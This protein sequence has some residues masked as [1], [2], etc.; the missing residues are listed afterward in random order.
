MR[1]VGWVRDTILSKGRTKIAAFVVKEG[2]WLRDTKILKFNDM[3]AYN[4]GSIEI[5]DIDKIQN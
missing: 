5:K 2:N 3:L 4:E 1:T